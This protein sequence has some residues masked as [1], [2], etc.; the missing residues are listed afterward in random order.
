MKKL[1]LQKRL[2]YVAVAASFGF[3]AA[4]ASSTKPVDNV[5]VNPTTD[6]YV[7]K[8]DDGKE[9]GADRAGRKEAREEA[10]KPAASG[11]GEAREVQGG[12]GSRASSGKFNE[13]ELKALADHYAQEAY[14]YYREANYDKARALA[15]DALDMDPGNAKAAQVRDDVERVLGLSRGESSNVARARS[16]E[17]QALRAEAIYEIDAGL[18]RADRLMLDGEY[19][20]AIAELEKVLDV[21]RWTGYMLDTEAKEREAR[22]MIEEARQKREEARVKDYVTTQEQERRIRELEMQEELDRYREQIRN[23]YSK[24]KEFFDR[25][26]YGETILVLNQILREDPYN[27]EVARLKNIARDLERGKADRDTWEAF[28]QNWKQVMAQIVHTNVFPKSTVELPDYEDWQRTEQRADRLERSR[29]TPLSKEDLAVRSALETVDLLLSFEEQT[30][31]D[32]IKK[33]KADG[34]I[35]ILRARDVPGETPVTI[36]VGRVKLRQALNLI[37]DSIELSWR[38][39]N[40][41]VIIGA[42]GSD[43]G[44]NVARRVFNVADLLVNLRTFK[45]DEPRLRTDANDTDRF[46]Q[47]QDRPEADPLTIEDLQ[48]VIEE[49]IDPD[50]WSKEG[51]GISTRQ[52]ELIILNNPDN[53]EKVAQLLNDLRRSQGLTVSVESRFITIRD[54][55]LEDIGLD[56]RG[57]GGS[58]QIPAPGNPPVPAALDDIQFGNNANPAGPGGTGNDAGFFFQD[59][60]PSGNV[61]IDQR[62]RVENLFDKALGGTRGGFGLTN[63]G[64]ASFQLA[65][66][67]NP[68]IN[69]IIRAVRKRERATLLTAPRITVHNTQRAHVSVLNEVAY[70]S[71]FNTSQATGIAVA[72]PVV[73]IIRDGIVLDVRPTVSADRRYI[74][75]ELRPTLALLLRPIPTFVTSLGVGSPVAI[76]TP[77]LTLQRIRTT[78]TVP[79]GG[80]FVIGGMRTMS[81]TDVESGIPILSDLPLIGSLFKRKGKSTVRQDIIIVVTARIIDLEEEIERDRPS[82]ENAPRDR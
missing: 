13:G 59:M 67:D 49:S 28:N 31:D 60:P 21:I 11:E 40:G 42:K 23:L 2:A 15:N 22:L 7:A 58:P 12:R 64:G 47:D 57:V 9:N 1:R 37:C 41:A 4:C 26:E 32:V 38:V 44:R 30:L 43:E 50:S 34:K 8:F 72:D 27:A 39:E 80:S 48:G 5:S 46:T 3:I 82:G 73:S 62:A 24:A 35:N 75:L 17:D 69:A 25:R 54:D 70:I 53:I 65:F 76:Q 19:N 16:S 10:S 20:K 74:T 45:G 29:K 51:H 77:Q 56:F 6:D 14:T 36:D 52:Q 71:D 55:F 79:D 66:V 33:L 63:S 78:V 61:R 81:E 18:D 68:E